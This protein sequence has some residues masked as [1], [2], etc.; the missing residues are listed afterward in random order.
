MGVEIGDSPLPTAHGEREA[1]AE[2]EETSTSQNLSKIS[3]EQKE[4]AIL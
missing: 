3:E 2:V 4:L 1:V